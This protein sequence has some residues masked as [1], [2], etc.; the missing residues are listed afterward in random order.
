MFTGQ[1]LFQQSCGNALAAAIQ[2]LV[3]NLLKIRK[4]LSNPCEGETCYEVFLQVPG[5]ADG[6]GDFIPDYPGCG[7]GP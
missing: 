5:R 1:T 3:Q 2:R 7:A 4:P 6:R